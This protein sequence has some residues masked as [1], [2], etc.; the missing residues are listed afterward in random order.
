MDLVT[1]NF[2]LTLESEVDEKGRELMNH[3]YEKNLPSEDLPVM[4]LMKFLTYDCSI[5]LELNSS[6]KADI[7]NSKDLFHI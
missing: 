1:D 4:S 3:L 6:L 2:Q 5:L 7:K